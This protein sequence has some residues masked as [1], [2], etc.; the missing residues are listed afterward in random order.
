MFDRYEV[1]FDE[2]GRGLEIRG[3][4]DKPAGRINWRK[5]LKVHY[6][7]LVPEDIELDI[8]TSGGSIHAENIA[9]DVMLKTS[10]GSLQL[11]DLAGNITARTSGGSIQGR[12]L[13]G[14]A[15]LAHFRR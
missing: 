14:I 9:G 10:G 3:E 5:G 4:Y 1:S 6:E 12:N 13:G 8:K 7:I 15:G 11:K 2:T